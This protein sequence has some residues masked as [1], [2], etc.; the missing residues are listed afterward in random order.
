[1]PSQGNIYLQCPYFPFQMSQTVS[2]PGLSVQFRQLLRERHGRRE[3]YQPRA[4]GYRRTRR[5]R[6]TPAPLLPTDRRL[7]D[8]LLDREPAILRQRESEMVPGD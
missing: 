7:P 3:T 5:L 2:K 1:M 6:P 4:V 8:M